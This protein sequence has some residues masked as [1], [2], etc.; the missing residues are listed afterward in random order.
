MPRRPRAFTLVEL[1][2]VVAVIALLIG[3]LLPALSAARKSAR[4][5]AC[6]S[7]LRQ[8]G[9]AHGA[10]SASNRDIVVPSYTMTG[11]T[12][13]GVPLEGWAP[14]FDRDGYIDAPEQ[15]HASAF[16]CPETADIPGAA[17]GQTG[18]F[19]ENPKG[20]M[21]W[22]F[23]R[24]GSANISRTIPER[25]FHKI[26]RVSYWINANNPI[27]SA[28]DIIPDLYYTA[29]VGYGP[30][31]NGVTLAY[32]NAA[33]FSSPTTLVVLADGLYAGRQRDNRLGMTN[34]RIGYRHATEANVAF[35]DGHAAPIDGLTFPRS[36]G[37]SNNPNE[38]REEIAHAQPTVYANPRKAL[39]L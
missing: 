21:D 6:L 15:S 4:S 34:S 35:A 26:I 5:A 25:R 7:N 29:S 3:L 10:Y 19:S 1:L 32:T 20:W 18:N 22:P 14:I 23:E 36:L 39:G 8:L 24:T 2:V 38:V 12:G 9:V 11:V 37:G 30:G 33:I 17:T 27:G 13:A 31:S 28:A 16:Y